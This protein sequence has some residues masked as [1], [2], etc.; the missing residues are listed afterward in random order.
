MIFE[1]LLLVFIDELDVVCVM[2]VCVVDLDE[3]RKILEEF[4]DDDFLIL[5]ID[6][7]GFEVVLI[8]VF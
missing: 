6:I 4:I 7:E 5:I 2:C 1:Y 8:V 3:L